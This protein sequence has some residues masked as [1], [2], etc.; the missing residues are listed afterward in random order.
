MKHHTQDQT[1]T[2][3]ALTTSVALPWGEAFILLAVATIL[4]IGG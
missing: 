4:L 1:P 2:F 3:R